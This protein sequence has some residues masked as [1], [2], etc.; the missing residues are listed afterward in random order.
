MQNVKQIIFALVFTSFLMG[1]ELK[2]KAPPNHIGTIIFQAEEQIENTPIVELGKAFTLSFDDLN[3]DE[4][5]YYYTIQHANADWTASELFKSEYINGFDEVRIRNMSNSSATLQSYTHYALSIPN[6]DTEIISSGNYVLSVFDDKQELVFTKRFVVYEQQAN[7]QVGVFRL[8]DLEGIDSKQRIEIGV[9]TAKINTRQPDQEI[10]VWALQNYRWSSARKIPKYDYVMNQ[11]L[12]FEYDN[13]LIFE[14]GNEYLFFDTKDIRS[15][16]GNVAYIRREN[17]YQSILYPNYVRNGTVYTYAPDINGNFVIQTTEGFN[18]NTDA[19]YTEVTFR[20]R[21]SETN[22]DF[23]V[24]GLFNQHLPQPVHKLEY[25]SANNLHQLTIRLK[26]GVYNYKYIAIGSAGQLFEN[27]VGG[28]YWE[29][30]NEYLAL[31]YMRKFGDRYD[32]LIGVGIG[33]SRQIQN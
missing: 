21:S 18:P 30:E 1:Q 11:S 6:R 15:A 31:V 14:G 33:N 19:D 20:L 32:R 29:T 17:L 25:D 5:Y 7:V 2:E 13:N 26:Q 27:G 24:T 28:S 9:Q 10:S 23:Y 4:A 3:A 22:Y 12:R 8:R 16:G